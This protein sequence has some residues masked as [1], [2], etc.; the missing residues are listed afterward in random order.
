MTR[1]TETAGE[2]IDVRAERPAILL[3]EHGLGGGVAKHVLDLTGLLQERAEFLLLMP[4]RGG[5][6]KVSRPRA[7]FSPALYFRVPQEIAALT[8]FLRASSIGR[9]HFHHTLRLDDKITELPHALGIP[10]DYTVHDYY[11]FCPQITL[12][13]EVFQYCGEPDEAGCERCLQI[14][15]ASTKESIH[16]WRARNQ[17]FVEGADRV[18]AP[19][20]SVE[21]RMRRYFPNA[22]IVLAPHPEP[23]EVT[24]PPQP[25]WR[26]RTGSLRIVVLGALNA[27]KGADLLEASAI[28][29]V[30]RALPLEFHLIGD[31]Y[32]N[33]SRA[34]GRLTVHGKYRNSDL[35]GLLERLAPD[36]TW[37]PARWPETYSYT[38][39]A[40]LREGLPVAATNLGAIHDRLGGRALS[41]A[42]PWNASERD[43]ND[44]F[45]AL[46]SNPS[47]GDGHC[48]SVTDNYSVPF[49]YSSHYLLKQPAGIARS[50]VGRDFDSHRNPLRASPSVLAQYI[51]GYA[52]DCLSAA[53]RLPGVRRL[54]V[55]VLPEHR[56]QLLRRWLDKF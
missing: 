21:Q 40:A 54:A 4:N 6:L 41:W 53:Y 33:L 30:D 8:E 36:L 9:I 51:K 19:S 13:T 5:L 56:L 52:R 20:R 42:L 43:W 29:A 50:G 22:A 49:S 11:S 12:T 7:E 46:R 17:R 31:A 34:A 18:F 1:S 14:R 55:A 16:A 47:Q 45:M 38:L 39:S 35:P 48:V 32:R 10:Y 23:V 44:F 37:F 27:I 25:I 2:P 24:S 3:I 28:D 15:P 26:H